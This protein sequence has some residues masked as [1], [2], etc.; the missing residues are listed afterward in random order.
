MEFRLTAE[1]REQLRASCIRPP[2][3][4]KLVDVKT[5][6]ALVELLDEL[7]FR[8]KPLRTELGLA[9]RKSL[10]AFIHANGLDWDP[11]NFATLP[12]KDGESHDPRAGWT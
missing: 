11:H 9:F 3:E 10:L 7:S 6:E 5:D 4:P 8:L 1:G 2:V 12:K